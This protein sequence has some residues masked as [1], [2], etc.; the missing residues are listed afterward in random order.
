MER[1]YNGVKG[2]RNHSQSLRPL[3]LGDWSKEL[4]VVNHDGAVLEIR[5]ASA[6]VGDLPQVDVDAGFCE[7]GGP[8]PYVDAAGWLLPFQHFMATCPAGSKQA[9]STYKSLTAQTLELGIMQT[10]ERNGCLHL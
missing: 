1:A 5:A 9:I 6:R 4:R 3:E 7:G 2:C 10:T 8:L